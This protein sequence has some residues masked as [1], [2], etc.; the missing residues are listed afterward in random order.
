MSIRATTTAN[1]STDVAKGI[2]RIRSSAVGRKL[3]GSKSRD[4]FINK[5]L[6]GFIRK[7]DDNYDH[8]LHRLAE[9]DKA[10]FEPDDEK[11][12][13]ATEGDLE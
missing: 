3:G 12:K 8:Y 13:S 10:Y 2:D 7:H 4:A 1:I 6:I 9:V 11:I 5:I